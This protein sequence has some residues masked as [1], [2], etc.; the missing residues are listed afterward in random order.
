M[1]FIFGS[2]LCGFDYV[3]SLKEKYSNRVTRLLFECRLVF[4]YYR[5]SKTFSVTKKIIWAPGH[6]GIEGNEVVDLLAMSWAESVSA[7]ISS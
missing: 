5:C 7:S 2:F 6:E 1:V 3:S 4:R